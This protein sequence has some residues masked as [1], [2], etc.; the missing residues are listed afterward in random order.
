MC[1]YVRTFF[2]KNFL[3]LFGMHKNSII[4]AVY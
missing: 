1:A 3:F 4:F 2:L